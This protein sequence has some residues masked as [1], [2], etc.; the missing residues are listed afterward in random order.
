MRG[1]FYNLTLS[2]MVWSLLL[3]REP[4]LIRLVSEICDWVLEPHTLA[5]AGV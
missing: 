5:D 2:V 4:L 3:N 1:D